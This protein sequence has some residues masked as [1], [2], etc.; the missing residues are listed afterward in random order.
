MLIFSH[1]I[2]EETKFKDIKHHFQKYKAHRITPS[3]WLRSYV[4][5][6]RLHGS[7]SAAFLIL[8]DIGL[9]KIAFIEK[10]AR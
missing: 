7:L 3:A 4:T 2:D 1:F 10:P 9:M 5:C 8:T 6:S